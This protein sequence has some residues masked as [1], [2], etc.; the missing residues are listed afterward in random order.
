MAATS[1]NKQ[2]LLVD[3]VLHE[4][5][6]LA[7][8]TIGYQSGIE[9]KGLNDAALLVD[10]TQGDGAIIEDIYSISNSTTP[11]FINLYLSTVNDYLRPN[12]GVFCSNFSSSSTKY[13]FTH[14]IQMPY[15]LAPVAQAGDGVL[16][17]PA[18]GLVVPLQF[19]ALYVPR[20]K[21]LWAAVEKTS[22]NDDGAFAP[23]IGVQGG[24]Y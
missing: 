4:V 13:D 19:R 23:I 8:R 12:Q 1:T 7:Y 3:R 5:Q 20:G 2:P 11:Y 17:D 14:L 16:T 6:S 15:I 21:S 18:D 24:Y 22:A 10:C 9:V